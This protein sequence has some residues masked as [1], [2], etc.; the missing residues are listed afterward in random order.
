[1]VSILKLRGEQ[2]I[3]PSEESSEAQKARDRR[4]YRRVA[5]AGAVKCEDSG[6]P[7]EGTLKNFSPIGVGAVF[8]R[9]PPIGT[10]VR[11]TLTLA[12]D[13]NP[14]Q[15]TGKVAWARPLAELGVKESKGRTAYAA[16]IRFQS[17]ESADKFRLT[18]RYAYFVMGSRLT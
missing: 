5:A 10:P 12:N 17:S 11:L 2:S 4:Q 8:E 13:P 1:M 7:S 16:G 9:L 15:I 18:L 6:E 14:L 3:R